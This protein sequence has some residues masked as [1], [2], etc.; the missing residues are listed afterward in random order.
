MRSVTNRYWCGSSKKTMHFST[1]EWFNEQRIET[2]SKTCASLAGER[3]DRDIDLAENNSPVL[4][5][6][7]R[8][9]CDDLLS[10]TPAPNC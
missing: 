8:K 10:T 9:D 1:C 4:I 7:T 6:F 5:L 2:S 3:L